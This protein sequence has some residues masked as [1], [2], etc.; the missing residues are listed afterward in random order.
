MAQASRFA[1]DVPL[2]AHPLLLKVQACQRHAVAG[3]VKK[4][5]HGFMRKN[6]LQP[7]WHM[8]R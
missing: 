5:L 6:W 2:A 8:R 4:Q 1:G 3:L 7:L